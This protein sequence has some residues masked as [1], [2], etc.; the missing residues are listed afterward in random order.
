MKEVNHRFTSLLNLFLLT[1]NAD[2]IV[3]GIALNI[4]DQKIKE[5]VILAR[6]EPPPH[7]NGVVLKYEV[8]VV[9]EVK[10]KTVETV[11]LATASP[12][13]GINSTSQE[14]VCV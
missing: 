3:S 2:D 4:T 5:H 11:T 14:Q 12:E 8:E 9:E 6:W 10:P 7:S 1:E 13:A